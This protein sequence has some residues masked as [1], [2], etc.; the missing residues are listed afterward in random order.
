MLPSPALPVGTS[1]VSAI[2]NL[3]LLNFDT[4][5]LALGVL[6]TCTIIR[7]DLYEIYSQLKNKLKEYDQRV[8]SYY[9][10]KTV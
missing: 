2:P 6:A 3:A 8:K 1:D 5:S 4:L 10:T 9:N 7:R